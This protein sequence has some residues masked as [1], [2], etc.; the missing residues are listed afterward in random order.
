MAKAR[1]L[2]DS[3]TW[4]AATITASSETG[5]MTGSNLVNDF[6]LRPW[7][8]TGLSSE[9]VVFDL[10]SAASIDVVSIQGHNLT[11]GATLV[12]EAHTADSWATPDY[13]ETLTI[14]TDADGVVYPRLTYFPSSA[15]TKQ[16]H[17]FVVTDTSNPDGYVQIGRI[18]AGQY[19]ELDRSMD[20]RF[21]I[22][23]IDPS[24]GADEEGRLGYYR[25]KTPFHR[26]ALNFSLHNETQ[27]KKIEALFRKVGRHTPFVV[28]L[29]PDSHPSE[30]S[31]YVQ[32]K[33]SLRTVFEIVDVYSQGTLVFT[34]V[35]E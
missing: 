31:Y 26:I 13:S 34:E 19:Y 20:D 17:R 29:D 27:K 16:Y 2:Y 6:L 30:W 5:D 21:T 11:S 18:K 12:H 23:L 8:P 15:I 1:L 3:D 25:V 7:R 22:E 14:L 9:S 28:A 10:G 32:L 33:S 35:V 24:E 4:D